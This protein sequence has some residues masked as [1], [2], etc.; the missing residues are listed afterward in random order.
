MYQ[1]ISKFV[2]LAGVS[3]L[4]VIGSSSLKRFLGCDLT[5]KKK[6]KPKT[7]IFGTF[8]KTDAID[9]HLATKLPSQP[10]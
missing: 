1:K 7:L 9:F 10:T 3:T 8:W 2:F 4:T 6:Q 5:N